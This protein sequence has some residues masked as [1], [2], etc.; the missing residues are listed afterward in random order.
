MNMILFEQ[1][2]IVLN[3]NM[4]FFCFDINLEENLL[5]IWMDAD[6]INNVKKIN[7]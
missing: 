4:N 1:V 3:Q 5:L 7:K 6:K 2:G